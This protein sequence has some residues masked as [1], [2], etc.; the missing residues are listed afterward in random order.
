MCIYTLYFYVYIY[1]YIERERATCVYIYIYIYVYVYI[2]IYIYVTGKLCASL[3]LPYLASRF[4][5]VARSASAETL[6]TKCW[7]FDVL[8]VVCEALDCPQFMRK[9][10]P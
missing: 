2:Y 4:S 1:I 10:S 8:P 9:Q 3:A 5:G 6:A 7:V